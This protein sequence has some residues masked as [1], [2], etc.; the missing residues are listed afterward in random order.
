VNVRGASLFCA[1]W[2]G[3]SAAP[4]QAQIY[5]AVGTRAQGLAGAFVALADDATMT[6]WNP[7]GLNAGPL[8]GG[9]VEYRTGVGDEAETAW[10]LSVAVPSLGLSFYRVHALPPLSSSSTGP[11]TGDR[12]DR[13]TGGT[14]L[15][16]SVWNQFGATV[17]FSVGDHIVLGSTL[18]LLLADQVRGDVDVGVLGTFGPA[19]AALVVKHVVAPDLTSDGVPLGFVRQVRIGAAWVWPPRGQLRMTGSVDADLTATPTAAGD[20]RH[21]AGGFEAWVTRFL[22]V[23]GGVSVNTVTDARPSASIGASAAVR[24]RFFID[25]Q[26]TGGKD[27]M[28][29]GWGL[30]ARVAF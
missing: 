15:P 4:A 6:W 24:S 17:G 5:E 16:A 20:E 3:S 19:R 12:Q 2:L 7:A 11:P 8:A 18:D 25:G 9:V 29:K 10:G 22:G 1:L 21:L 30:G 13:R 27:A 26:V 14:S 28:T 23:R